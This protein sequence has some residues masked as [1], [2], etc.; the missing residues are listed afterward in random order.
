[1]LVGL[2]LMPGNPEPM[3]VRPTGPG[4]SPSEKYTHGFRL[5]ATP[6]LKEPAT[7]FIPRGWFFPDRV[8]EV[9][10]GQQICVRLTGLLDQGSNFERVSY[11]GA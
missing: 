8:I 6:S 3:A 10:T 1:L 4:V 7:L 5:A 11:T 9:Y 2:L